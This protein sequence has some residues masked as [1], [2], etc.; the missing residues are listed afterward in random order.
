MDVHEYLYD[1]LKRRKSTVL[2]R[3]SGIVASRV[4][5]RLLDDIERQIAEFKTMGGPPQ[6]RA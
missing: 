5:Q 2:V 1:E 6:G 3:G 4:L